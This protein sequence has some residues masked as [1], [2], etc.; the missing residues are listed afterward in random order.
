MLLLH[1]TQ[2]CHDF[3]HA[4]NCIYCVYVEGYGLQ[5]NYDALFYSSPIEG[6]ALLVTP[7]G[8]DKKLHVFRLRP[9][10]V[11]NKSSLVHDGLRK[12][13]HGHRMPEKYIAVNVIGL[14]LS[15][16]STFFR[17]V[18]RNP[19]FLGTAAFNLLP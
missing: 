17:R 18:F 3:P 5:L 14:D 1:S 2:C 12:I 4:L 6:A 9:C 8:C 7:L 15:A 19:I 11:D 13:T 16:S 10:H